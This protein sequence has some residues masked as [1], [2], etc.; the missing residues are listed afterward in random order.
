M[1]LGGSSRLEEPRIISLSSLDDSLWTARN[2]N[3][4]QRRGT[5]IGERAKFIYRLKHEARH[6]DW[7]WSKSIR[8]AI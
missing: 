2:C 4:H 8:E 5:W 7:K 3:I 6:Y 1:N